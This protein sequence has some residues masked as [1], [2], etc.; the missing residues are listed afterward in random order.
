MWETL[1]EYPEARKALL[2][3]GKEI[4]MKDNM[5][6]EEKA[7]Q[8]AA[9]H[10]TQAETVVRNSSLC[11]LINK[12]LSYQIIN[13]SIMSLCINSPS[14]SFHRFCLC[15]AQCF[16]TCSYTTLEFCEEM[17]VC[18]LE[19]E[20]ETIRLGMEEL[21]NKY[22]LLQVSMNFNNFVLCCLDQII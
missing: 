11:N 8:E 19:G 13:L 15:F 1:A 21:M 10:E 14:L 5:I 17:N 2:E 4:L 9:A 18:R 16:G 20:L 22:Q 3:K 12:R 7:K 6:D